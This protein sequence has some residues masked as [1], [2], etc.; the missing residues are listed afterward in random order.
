MNNEKEQLTPPK[1]TF[2]RDV[3]IY[4]MFLTGVIVLVVVSLFDFVWAYYYEQTLPQYSINYF[5]FRFCLG[6]IFGFFSGFI[7]WL[8]YVNWSKKQTGISN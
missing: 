5:V 4:G 6:A 1:V 3:I 7:G 2:I 8:S